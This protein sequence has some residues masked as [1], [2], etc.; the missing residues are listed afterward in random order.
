MG[1]AYLRERWN[2]IDSTHFLFIQTSFEWNKTMVKVF[3]KRTLLE[4]TKFL[5]FKKNE[6]PFTKKLAND[7]KDFNIIHHQSSSSLPTTINLNDFRISKRSPPEMEQHDINV[8]SKDNSDD[9]FGASASA[10]ASCVDYR[11]EQQRLINKEQYENHLSWVATKIDILNERIR[12]RP[13]IP[14]IDHQIWNRFLSLRPTDGSPPPYLKLAKDYFPPPLP[15]P[16]PPP[17]SPL[18]HDW[19]EPLPLP[20]ASYFP[21]KRDP[22]LPELEVIVKNKYLEV[23]RDIETCISQAGS[24]IELPWWTLEQLRIAD[25]HMEIIEKTE[26]NTPTERDMN[27]LSKWFSK[28][29]NLNA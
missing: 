23:K 7:I 20:T 13:P 9:E 24:P 2:D 11:H 14:Y 8:E 16:P 26:N 27:N 18:S 12:S 3:K 4:H 21:L 29:L 19:D 22:S 28:D 15:P 10:S 1:W 5:F 17:P 25:E 6:S